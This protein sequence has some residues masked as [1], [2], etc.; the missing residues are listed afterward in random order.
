MVAK[1]LKA[2]SIIEAQ[3]IAEAAA[4]RAR[5]ERAMLDYIGVGRRAARRPVNLPALPVLIRPSA[6]DLGAFESSEARRLQELLARLTV[7]QRL[8]L[9]ALA[10]FGKS[11]SLDFDAALR[12]ARRV[13]PEAQVGYLMSRRLELHIPAGLDRLD[14]ASPG[15]H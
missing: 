12:R 8:E 6:V 3:A 7:A 1:L 5:D 9:I 11:A 10:W 15:G 14:A 2:L 13:P 4:S